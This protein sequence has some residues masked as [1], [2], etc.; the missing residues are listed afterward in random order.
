[1]NKTRQELAIGIYETMMCD[2]SKEQVLEY[3]ESKLDAYASQSDNRHGFIALLL[4]KIRELNPA[5]H[6]Q[7]VALSAVQSMITETDYFGNGKSLLQI[8]KELFTAHQS[9]PPL[10]PVGKLWSRQDILDLIKSKS[11]TND[12]GEHLIYVTALLNALP[13]Q[14]DEGDGCNKNISQ[15][16]INKL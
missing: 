5:S 7:E 2:G 12:M 11:F 14:V 3:I 13:L 10:L 6:S 15:E 1:M 16:N 4:S 8:E 9:A